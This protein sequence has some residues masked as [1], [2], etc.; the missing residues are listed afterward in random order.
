ML[1]AGFVLICCYLAD[2]P[3]LAFSLNSDVFIQMSRIMSYK[4]LFTH[5]ANAG[6]LSKWVELRQ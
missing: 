1:K 4:M 6:I 2:L 3:I 5:F